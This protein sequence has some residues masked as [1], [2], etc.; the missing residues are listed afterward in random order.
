MSKKI[1][2]AKALMANLIGTWVIGNH[3]AGQDRYGVDGE[4]L[5]I[6]GRAYRHFS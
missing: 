5:G 2:I 6:L 4:S 3:Q 1:W